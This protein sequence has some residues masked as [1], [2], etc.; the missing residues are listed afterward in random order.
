[1]GLTKMLRMNQED[2][3]T[4]TDSAVCKNTGIVLAGNPS[5]PA[6]SGDGSCTGTGFSA[7]EYPLWYVGIGPA[8]VCWNTL[9]PMATA[10]PT[11][12]LRTSLP[13]VQAQRSMGRPSLVATIPEG[14]FRAPRRKR[15]R[16]SR[17]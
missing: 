10:T 9:F 13:L 12:A 11:P 7:I 16:V 15:L 4:D 1:M 8:P 3:G 5:P 17:C 2:P 6:A 14:P